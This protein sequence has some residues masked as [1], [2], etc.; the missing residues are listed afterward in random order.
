[1][2]G[3]DVRLHLVTWSAHDFGHSCGTRLRGHPSGPT[4][5]G[6]ILLISLPAV[7]VA[8]V[9]ALQTRSWLRALGY[10]I[11]AAVL[12]AVSVAAA[13]ILWV[14]SRDCGE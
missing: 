13:V 12:A 8:A 1:M 2:A 6:E 11:A 9:Q 14:V 5:A 7:I 10:G 3:S 4:T